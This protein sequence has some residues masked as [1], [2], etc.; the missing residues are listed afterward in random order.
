MSPRSD[1]THTHPRAR[2]LFEMSSHSLFRELDSAD[3][4][5]EMCGC[6]SLCVVCACSLCFGVY[7]CS[8]I[9]GFSVAFLFIEC[10]VSFVFTWD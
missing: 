6:V 8:G 2:W 3:R 4:K 1:H 9:S 5:R 7:V 10:L